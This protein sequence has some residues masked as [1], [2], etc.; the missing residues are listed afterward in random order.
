VSFGAAR[1]AKARRRAPL[2]LTFER[3]DWRFEG[4]AGDPV[5]GRGYTVR[6][7]DR[8]LA[9]ESPRLAEAGVEIMKVAGTSYRAEELQ[10]P[11]FAPGSPLVLRAEPDNPHDPNAVAVW[12]EAGTA[13][14]GY[15]SR[16]RAA[17]VAGR[18]GELDALALWEWRGADGRR[19]G[20]RILLAPPELLAVRPPRLAR[21]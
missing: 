2:R 1:D 16:D 21:G 15:V 11:G 13:Q 7:G 14:A 8:P 17:G 5:E 12:D 9:W 10:D 4:G 18:L 20:L 19:F 3:Q 6:D